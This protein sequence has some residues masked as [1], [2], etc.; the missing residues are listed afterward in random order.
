MKV[1]STRFGELEIEESNIITFPSGIPGFQDERR[2]FLL[3]YKD[4][5]KW[6][7]S[8]DSPELAFIVIDPFVLFPEYEFTVLDEV[9]SL[10]EIER[11]EG[12]L[13]LVILIFNENRLYAN[14]KA[15]IIVNA[16]KMKATQ[17]IIDDDRYSFRALVS[18]SNVAFTDSVAR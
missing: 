17:I 4:P 2:F 7:H 6:L 11:P 18:C 9:E 10:L 5:I 12:L 14:L 8:A 15:P 13:S 1:N 3:D 16:D